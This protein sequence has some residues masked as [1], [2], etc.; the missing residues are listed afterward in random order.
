MSTLQSSS[1]RN[2]F[3]N[4]FFRFRFSPEATDNEGPHW[5][6]NLYFA[7]IIELRALAKAAP[8]LRQEKYFTGIDEEDL[9]VRAAVNDLLNII[10]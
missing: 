7:Y 2:F 1:S 5:L 4:K 6:K 9:A 3:L 10:E 8:Y